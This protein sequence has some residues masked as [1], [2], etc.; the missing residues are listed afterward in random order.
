M[1]AFQIA[2]LQPLTTSTAQVIGVTALVSSIPDGLF[3][4]PL[5]APV[6]LGANTTYYFAVYNT[7]NGSEIGGR[8][9]GLGTTIDAPPINFRAQNLTGFTIGDIIN[10]SDDSLFLS[11]WIAGT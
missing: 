4:L 10:T 7:V 9:T 8:S 6:A 5:T 2:V 3:T 1:G 11:P